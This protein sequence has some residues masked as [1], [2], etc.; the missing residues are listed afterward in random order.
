[1]PFDDVELDEALPVLEVDSS[2]KQFREALRLATPE[3]TMRTAFRVDLERHLS[4]LVN[5][6]PAHQRRRWGLA[7]PGR[8]MLPFG[9]ALVA[10]FALALGVFESLQ[11][12]S[13]VGARELLRRAD[14][15]SSLVPPGK[16]RHIV[17]SYTGARTFTQERWYA[18]GQSHLLM[19]LQD[20]LS[21]QVVIMG[22]DAVWRYSLHD[23][24]IYEFADAS[25]VIE[26]LGPAPFRLDALAGDQSARVIGHGSLDRRAATI[27]QI[28]HPLSFQGPP[29]TAT[30]NAPASETQE[31]WIDS[32]NYQLLQMRRTLRDSS[33][34]V[35]QEIDFKVAVNELRGYS[36]FPVGFFSFTPPPGAKIIRE[37]TA[38]VPVSPMALPSP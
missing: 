28:D 15:A 25:S 9:L 24:Q 23:D 31:I 38:A 37:P 10:V 29:S 19:R 17:Y 21:D 32:Q 12:A 36:Q 8:R 13:P 30:L 11:G 4:E 2:G 18:N 27:V 34:R 16:V 6:S 14:T 35:T 26:D 5:R 33:G 3:M 22:N 20:G 7:L 1:M